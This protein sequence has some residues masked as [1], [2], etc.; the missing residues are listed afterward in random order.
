MLQYRSFKAQ[1][2]G[3]IKLILVKININDNKK[4]L[5]NI[6]L[7][8]ITWYLHQEDKDYFTTKYIIGI[9]NIFKG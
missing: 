7:S 2:H 6:I 3:R 9:E 8:D 1:V 5:V 4:E